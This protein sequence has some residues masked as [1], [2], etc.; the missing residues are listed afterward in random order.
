[1]ISEGN[2]GWCVQ[3]HSTDPLIERIEWAYRHRDEVLEMG[4]RA[5]QRAEQWTWA[6]YRRKL[7]EELSP[8]LTAQGA[9]TTIA[10]SWEN[11][12]S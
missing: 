2:E 7:I 11:A 8:F 1:L 10:H 6:D 4:R 3:A 9:D 5:R 12:G